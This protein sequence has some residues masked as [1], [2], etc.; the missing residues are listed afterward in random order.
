MEG[1]FAADDEEKTKLEDITTKQMEDFLDKETFAL[2]TG[3]A[4]LVDW[5]LS[6]RDKLYEATAKIAKHYLAVNQDNKYFV[7]VTS[8]NNDMEGILFTKDGDDFI[9]AGEGFAEKLSLAMDSFDKAKHGNLSDF[10]GKFKT[11]YGDRKNFDVKNFLNSYTKSDDTQ[12]KPDTKAD[13]QMTP[14]EVADIINDETQ[15]SGLTPQDL[16][17]LQSQA[18]G[19]ELAKINKFIMELGTPIESGELTYEKKEQY[20]ALSECIIRRL[21]K[22]SKTKRRF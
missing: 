18:H 16:S 2:D 11:A 21:F 19:D 17:K 22:F 8:F 7:D 9:V 1:Y 6:G 10:L 4:E 13:T 15:L 14:K 5:G 12:A 3:I 20:E